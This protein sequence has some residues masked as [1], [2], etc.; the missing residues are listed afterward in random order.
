MRDS[1]DDLRRLVVDA[2]GWQVLDLLFGQ[3]E[4]DTGVDPGYGADRD[5]DFL[6]AEEVPFLEE[7]VT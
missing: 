7:H 5:G 1:E 4:P 2:D 3:V 6:A